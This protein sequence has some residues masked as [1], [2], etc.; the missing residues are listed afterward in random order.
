MRNTLVY[1]VVNIIP[2][3]I[4]AEDLLKL[5]KSLNKELNTNAIK[6]NPALMDHYKL[7]SNKNIKDRK[8]SYEKLIVQKDAHG[9]VV[10]K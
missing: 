3:D 5:V 8:Y 7:I 6:N 2:H 1:D 10:P 9:S 4:S